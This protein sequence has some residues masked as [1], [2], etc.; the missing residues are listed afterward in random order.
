MTDKEKILK[1]LEEGSITVEEASNL[2]DKLEM[3][4]DNERAASNDKKSKSKGKNVN[5]IIEDSTGHDRVNIYMPLSVLRFAL[6]FNNGHIN[7]DGK[8]VN[9]SE[10]KDIIDSAEIGT[11]A[12]IET[13][14]GIVKISI[15]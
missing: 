10:I 2:L 11:I 9:V 14:S 8:Q 7:V 1:L 12:D 15:I 4:D 5:I 3:V 6:K 13:S